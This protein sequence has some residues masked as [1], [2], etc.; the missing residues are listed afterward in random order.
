MLSL[1][2]INTFCNPHR[3]L[4]SHVRPFDFIGLK[5]PFIL[6]N[7]IQT[8]DRVLIGSLVCQSKA[9][10]LRSTMASCFVG[11]MQAIKHLKHN[12][13]L[14]VESS[15]RKTSESFPLDTTYCTVK[16]KR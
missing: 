8:L 13:F 14:P 3:A 1:N 4:V 6:S 7:G 15:H 11:F 5:I 9:P 12:R 2:G 10:V 16:K